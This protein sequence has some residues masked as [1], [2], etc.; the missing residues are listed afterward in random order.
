MV[1]VAKTSITLDAQQGSNGARI[2]AVV[3]HQAPF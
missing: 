1:E 3:D 2:V